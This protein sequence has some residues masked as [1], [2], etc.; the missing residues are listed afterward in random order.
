MPK[1]KHS[2]KE[3]IKSRKITS[4]LILLAI[5]GIG[6]WGY[7]KL[8]STSGQ[9]SYVVTNVKRGNIVSTV[10]GT[11]QVTASSQTDI[12]SKVSGDIVYLNTRANGTQVTKG[13]LIAQVDTRDAA[14][15]LENAK[16][17]YAK[18]IKPADT[19]TMLQAQ[20]S[21]DDAVLANKKAYDDAFNTVTSSFSDF[22]S[23]MTGIEDL[24]YN[25]SGYL[26]VEKVRLVSQTAL[27]LQSKA[28]ISFDKAKNEYNT[29]LIDY[30]NLSRTSSNATIESFVSSS[31]ILAK[32]I[33]ESVKNIQNTLDYVRKQKS[34]GTGSTE[35]TNV[36]SWVSTINS[37]VSDLLSSKTAITSTLQD[38]KQKNAD[39]V[40]LKTGADDLDIASQ[41][42]SLQQAQNNYDNYFIRAP[43]DGLLARLSIKSTDSVSS[44][45]VIGTLVSTQKISTIT[46]NEVD[47]EKVRVGQKV[48]LTFDAVEGLTIDGTVI[49]VDLVGTISQG[50]VNYNVEMSLDTQDDR[51]KSGMS[52]TATIITDTKEN[53]LVVPNSAVK[54]QGRFNYVEVFAT[55]LTVTKGVIGTPSSV[56][57]IQKRV[58]IGTSNDSLTEIV[59][60]LNEGDQ[61]VTRTIVGTTVT[62]TTTPTATSLF[63]NGARTGTSGTT[64]TG[65]GPT[66]PRN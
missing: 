66:S 11:G 21:Y 48:K 29:L 49:T 19:P 5:I 62:K 15:S 9:T 44:G 60:G 34:D 16:I 32:D 58:E 59:S 63:G 39:L 8:T 28:G 53:V 12:K 7:S 2:I 61:V 14:I 30:K 38:V 42:L 17:A 22:P 4:A 46:L 35:S 24:I 31:Y 1:I 36:S 43:F 57:P 50:V 6:Y 27:D 37:D 20:S 40:K 18:L 52:V 33:S 26:T 51:V 13:T 23:I 3:F 10:T 64:R 41:K 54:T 25:Q 55:P 56:P 65:N 45:T 47:V